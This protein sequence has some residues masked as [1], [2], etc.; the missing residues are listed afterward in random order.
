MS[1]YENITNEL[2]ESLLDIVNEYQTE[3]D[4]EYSV[5]CNNLKIPKPNPVINKRCC[6]TPSRECQQRWKRLQHKWTVRHQTHGNIRDWWD[7]TTLEYQPITQGQG[8]RPRI[9]DLVTVNYISKRLDGMSL[10]WSKRPYTFRVGDNSV[11][12][13]LNK[14][15]TKINRGG[16]GKLYIPAEMAYGWEGIGTLI[17]PHTDIIM[18]VTLKKIKN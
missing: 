5:H 2:C 17:P 12:E 9:G 18:T 13:G 8:R 3:Y 15:I 6:Q 11:M 10:D 4:N 14:G 7:T 1:C 16:K